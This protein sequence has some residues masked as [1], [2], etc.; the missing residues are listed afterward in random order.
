S[1]EGNEVI[2]QIINQM[3]LIQNAVQDLSSII[4]SLETRSKEISDIVT[5]ITGISNQT[6][7]LALNASI[8]AARAGEQGKGFAVVADEVRKLAEQSK[9]AATDINQLL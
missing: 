5:V 6:N 1:I 4:Y 7:L 2:G 9:T 3:S 8:E